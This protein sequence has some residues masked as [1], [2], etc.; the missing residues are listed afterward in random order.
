MEGLEL[1][2]TFK[3]VSVSASISKNLDNR[4]FKHFFKNTFTQMGKPFC[5]TNVNTSAQV[6]IFLL[7]KDIHDK[8]L[9]DFSMV[10]H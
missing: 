3:N 4:I 1:N 9:T 5:S 6:S 10:E 7:G 8:S 2:H